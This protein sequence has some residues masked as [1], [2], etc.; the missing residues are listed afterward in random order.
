MLIG[1]DATLVAEYRFAC[2]LCEQPAGEVKLYKA[3][4]GAV[5]VCNSF[6]SRFEGLV[7]LSQFEPLRIAISSGDAKTLYQI[8]L[9]YAPFYCPKCARC[10][11]GAHW[12][13]WDV[14]EE[15]GWHDSIRGVCPQG[16]E[17]MLE[18]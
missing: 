15:D 9:E 17:R 7:E 13:K 6:T 12:R 18:D 5:I 14:F 2:S 4:H 1:A 16:H 3:A 11:C 10:F 8:N